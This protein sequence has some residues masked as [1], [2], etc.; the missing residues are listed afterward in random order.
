ML[1]TTSASTRPSPGTSPITSDDTRQRWLPRNTRCGR[2]AAESAGRRAAR[3]AKKKS[4]RMAHAVHVHLNLGEGYG[5]MHVIRARFL[6]C[7]AET[8]RRSIVGQ[9]DV[10]GIVLTDA[11]RWGL[12]LVTRGELVSRGG[13]PH[14]QRDFTQG[15]A[16]V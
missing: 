12:E 4:G 9:L 14:T 6:P 8:I 15:F 11:E 1:P 10:I 13:G 2:L 16:G 3:D 7:D 5:L